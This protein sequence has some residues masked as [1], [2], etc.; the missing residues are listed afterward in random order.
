MVEN[1]EGKNI[2]FI[3]A[4]ASIHLT[5]QNRQAALSSCK[6]FDQVELKRVSC[7]VCSLSVIRRIPSSRNANRYC[8]FGSIKFQPKIFQGVKKSLDIMVFTRKFVQ[9]G[10][11]R[12]VSPFMTSQRCHA[13][14][15]MDLVTADE[16]SHR[17]VSIASTVQFKS[18]ERDY[19]ATSRRRSMEVI[20]QNWKDSWNASSENFVIDDCV[21]MA[22]VVSTAHELDLIEAAERLHLYDKMI[23]LLNLGEYVKIQEDSYSN[24]PATESLTGRGVGHALSLSRRT[25][26]F[27][28]EEN[29]LVPELFIIEPSQKAAQTGFLSFPYD[30]PYSSLHGTRW[31]CHPDAS[32]NR[33]DQ[34]LSTSLSL[35]NLGIDCS[36]LSNREPIDTRSSKHNL[37]ESST[38]LLNWICERDEKI[39][40]GKLNYDFYWVQHKRAH[41]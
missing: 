16:V 33:T 24:L 23:F 7:F 8:H 38:N 37:A 13:T 40:V 32:V 31:I 12:K 6:E 19:S 41:T 30:T 18:A 3:I 14:S 15:T 5:L 9:N 25:A 4:F 39:V 29:G 1:Q 2:L 22:P 36:L 34:W 11:R 26:T 35:N 27:C 10:S 21:D 20:Q 28:N 17:H